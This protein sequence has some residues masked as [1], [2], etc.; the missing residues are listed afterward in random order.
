MCIELFDYAFAFAFASAWF[1]V[2]KVI[3]AIAYCETWRDFDI[4]VV[5]QDYRF[6]QLVLIAFRWLIL[7]NSY[8]NIIGADGGR[9]L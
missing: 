3:D 2:S 1:V 7:F 4:P 6:S 5:M 9:L 8:R